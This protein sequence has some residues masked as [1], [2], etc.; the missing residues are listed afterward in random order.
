[1]SFYSKFFI[2]WSIS[3]YPKYYMFWGVII[4]SRNSEI[5]EIREIPEIFSRKFLKHRLIISGNIF[6]NFGKLFSGISRISGN[7][8]W[9]LGKLFISRITEIR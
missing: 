3:I 8:S 9:N 2:F 1:M 7:S 4:N 5:P 6:G